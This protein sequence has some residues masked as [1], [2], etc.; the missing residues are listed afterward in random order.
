MREENN[1][2]SVAAHVGLSWVSIRNKLIE[3][4]GNQDNNPKPS[5]EGTLFKRGSSES[6]YNASSAIR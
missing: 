6:V 1:T 5:S 2:V 4:S 3:N